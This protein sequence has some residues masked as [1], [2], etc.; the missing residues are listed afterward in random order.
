MQGQTLS[1]VTTVGLFNFKHMLT[2]SPR[3]LHQDTCVKM[4]RVGRRETCKD[5]YY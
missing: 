3:D 4:G 2:E 1:W 5:V